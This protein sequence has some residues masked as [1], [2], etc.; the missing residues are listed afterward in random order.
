[1]FFRREKGA[2]THI[3]GSGSG[4]DGFDRPQEGSVKVESAAIGLEYVN[5]GVDAFLFECG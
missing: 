2:H 5:G 3:A 1:M 4:E